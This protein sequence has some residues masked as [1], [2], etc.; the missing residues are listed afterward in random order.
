MGLTGYF[1]GPLVFYFICCLANWG[2]PIRSVVVDLPSVR[3]SKGNGNFI[4]SFI[5]LFL[6]SVPI[7][8]RRTDVDRQER[9]GW[10]PNTEMPTYGWGLS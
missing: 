5:S 9:R 4:L 10:E 8:C 7:T 1:D 3:C 6:S 2:A